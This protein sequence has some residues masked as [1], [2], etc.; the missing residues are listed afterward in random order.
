MAHI[1]FENNEYIIRDDWTADDIHA[2]AETMNVKLTDEQVTEVMHKIVKA[3]DSEVGI[4]WYSIQS[5][6]EATI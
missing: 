3:F 6:I 2:E 4:N 5:A 1:V